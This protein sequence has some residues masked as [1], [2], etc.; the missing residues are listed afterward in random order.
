[1]NIN[2]I[3]KKILEIPD[4][5]TNKHTHSNKSVIDKAI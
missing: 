1:M 2:D 3:L 4:L 5:V